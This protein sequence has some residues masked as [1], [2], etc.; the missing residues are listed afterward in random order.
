LPPQ[1]SSYARELDTLH[2]AVIAA[3]TLGATVVF[4][5]L[6]VL[7]LVYRRRTSPRKHVGWRPPFWVEVATALGLLALFVGFWVVGVRQ[8]ARRERPPADALV[9]YVVAKQ[10][11][12]SFAYPNGARSE[13]TLY[14]PAGRPVVLSMTSRDVIHSFYVP[15]FRAKKDVLP[16]RVTELW[17]TAVTPGTY[18]IFCAEYCGFEHSLMR[19]R[20][21]ALAPEDYAGAWEASPIAGRAPKLNTKLALT[22]AG[23]P[24]AV[25]G[26]RVAAE[27]GC[28]RCHTTDGTPHV[29][30]TWVGV[31]GHEVALA[32]DRRVIADGPYLTESMMD[33]EA[34]VRRG[35]PAIMPSYRGV[36]DPTEVGALLEL[37]RSL[38]NGPN[39]APAPLV[40]AGTP[41]VSLPTEAEAPAP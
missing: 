41:P 40:S 24:L 11:M 15:A 35:F 18:P 10:W 9:V 38:E 20:V 22:S 27:R 26:E 1:A 34:K 13:E 5:A 2:Y 6:V 36:L 14:V 39:A 4:V 37:F 30:P 33:P 7:T 31:Y 17:F 8:Y 16:G 12:W 3:T 32:G 21:V 19:G 29:G 25:V 23:T 28:L